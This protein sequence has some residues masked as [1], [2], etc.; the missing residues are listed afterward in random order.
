MLP[1]TG[2]LLKQDFVKKEQ[3][4]KTFQLSANRLSGY[5]DNREAVEQA[6]F[7]I[8]NTE[9]FDCLIYSWNYGVEQKGLYGKPIN[10]VKSEIKKRITKALIQDDRILD[11]SAFSFEE[12]QK[13]LQV[14]FVV[15]TVYGDINAKKEVKV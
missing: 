15:H 9:R 5:I 3:P 10:Y 11:V 1:G 8:L 12:F 7:C 14:T 2:E 4:S 6:V 13:S